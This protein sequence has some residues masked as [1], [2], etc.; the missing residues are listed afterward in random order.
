MQLLQFMEIMK[1]DIM[2]T[3]YSE[4][5][6]SLRQGLNPAFFVMADF[7]VQYNICDTSLDVRFML[8]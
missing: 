3:E 2:R 5:A 7:R 1:I 8:N 4:K 6:G